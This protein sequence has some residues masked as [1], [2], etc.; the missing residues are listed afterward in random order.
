MFQFPEPEKEIK[1]STGMPRER[2]SR[3]GC[4]RASAGTPAKHE[5]HRPSDR[6]PFP[7]VIIGPK[8]DR[9]LSKC[10]WHVAKVSPGSPVVC[11]ETDWPDMA[12]RSDSSAII[13][14]P[15]RRLRCCTVRTST[16]LA[17]PTSSGRSADFFFRAGS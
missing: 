8:C 5:N 15:R 14:A 1:E 13:T 4:P 7:A 6:K 11:E 10:S 12:A 16:E 2:K 3:E 9:E 17:T